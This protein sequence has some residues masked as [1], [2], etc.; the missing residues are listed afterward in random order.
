MES[1]LK[2]CLEKLAL[3]LFGEGLKNIFI[4]CIDLI[5]LLKFSETETRWVESVFPFT[6]PSFELEI[7]HKNDWMELL[8][9]GIIRQEILANCEFLKKTSWKAPILNTAISG[10]I[11]DQV[12]WAFGLGLERLAMC[13]YGIPDI[14]LF[15]STDT[16]FMN[17]FR[18][19][20]P[21]TK[22]TYK[23]S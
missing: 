9:C 4:D 13:M 15:W 5:P 17:Q 3:S 12:G 19:A 7:R 10:G 16:G 21:T 22:V 23:V 8:G 6:H 2:K 14:R 20:N 18:N 11:N 1:D